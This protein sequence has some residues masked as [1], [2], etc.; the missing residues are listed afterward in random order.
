MLGINESNGMSKY[1]PVDIELGRNFKGG[2]GEVTIGI[3]CMLT[4]A[5]GILGNLNLDAEC[6]HAHEIASRSNE[7]YKHL[8][9]EY[10]LCA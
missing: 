7:V 5:K 3:D 8:C 1:N 2:S 6:R 10:V 9:S 4:Y